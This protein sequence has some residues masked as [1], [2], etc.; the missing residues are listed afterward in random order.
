METRSKSEKVIRIRARLGMASL[1]IVDPI[2]IV[3]GLA[4]L[5]DGGSVEMGALSDCIVR[6]REQG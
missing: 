5:Y 1:V 4:L 2:G 6:E 3:G